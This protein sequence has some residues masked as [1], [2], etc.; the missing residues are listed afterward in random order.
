[1]VDQRV[2][3]IQ[4]WSGLGSSSVL[5]SI[6][7][8][9][10]SR[11]AIPKLCF[12]RIILIDS[13]EWRSRR[14]MQRAIAEELK[15]D[16]STM[17][18]ID[19]QDEEDDFY[20][21][22]DRSRGEIAAVSRK[23]N[24]I[25]KDSRFVMLFHK[26]CDEEIVLYG[27]GVPRF[28]KF[29]DNLLIWTSGRRR[30][31]F[32][33]NDITTR[34]N[35]QVYEG[36]VNLTNEQFYA[37]LCKEGAIIAPGI[38]P[39]VVS[40]CFLYKLLL[41]VSFLTTTKYDWAGHAFNCWICDGILQVDISREISNVLRRKISM[42]GDAYLLDY[43]LRKFKKYLKLPFLRVKDGDVYEEG[44]YRWISM[45]SKDT[46][47]HGMQI[48]PAQTSSFFLEFE[49]SEPLLAL[50]TGLFEHSSILGVL[51]LC[52]CAF[53]FA[54]PPFAKCHSLKFLGLDH[55]TDNNTCEVEDHTEWVC[56]YLL[57][58][59]DLHYTKW[60]EILSIKNIDLMTNIRE[61]NI[62]GFICWQ[63]TTHLQ[64][65]L[66]NLER[67][68]IIKPGSEP[69]ISLDT[70][71]SFLG[72]TKL[73]ILDLSGN[74]NM[75]V[76]PSSLSEVSSLDVLVL[77]GCTKLQDVV[78]DVLPHLLRSFRLD[79]YGPP[80]RRIPNVEQPMEHISS[81]TPFR[82]KKIS[83][84]TGSNK[85]GSNNISRI[86]LQGC[87]RLDSLFLRGLP[88][89]VELDLSGS[90]IK[91][92]DFETMVVEVPGLKRLFLLGC[93]HLRAIGW[94]KRWILYSTK[95][96]LEL[97]CIDTRA[98]TV[99]PRP[100]LSKNK[101][102]RLQVHAVV[103][104]ARLAWSL[105]PPMIMGARD[106]GLKE[107]YFNIH[108]TSSL[109]HN[110]SV[111]LREL[112]KKKTSMHGDQVSMQLSGIPPGSQY[113]DVFSMVSAVPLMQAFPEP[114]TSNLDYHIEIGEGGRSLE[115]AL[116]GHNNNDYNYN[117]RNLA[118]IMKWFAESLHVHDVSVSG[119]MPMGYWNMLKQCRMERCPKL[120]TVFP[121]GSQ[122]NSSGSS[123]FETL[124]T[125]WACDLLMARQIWSKGSHINVTS[126]KSFRNLQHLHLSSCPRLQFMLPVWVSSFPSLETLHIIHCG[127]L[128]HIFVLDGWYPEEIATNGVAFP[129]L[130]A[131]YLHDLPT[132]R[133]ISEMMMVAP[134]LETIKIRGCW[135]LSRLPAMNKSRGP[136]MKK[137]TVE[138]E[139][140][141]WDAL[142]WDGVEA[143]HHPSHF[144][145]PVHSRYYKKKLPR[146]SVL[147]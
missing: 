22:H 56:L 137:P 83:S 37:I 7:E 2:F 108:V 55:C 111:Q 139:K 132:L 87:T 85:N 119:S 102:L 143:G 9:L 59:L 31:I 6:A 117:D 121:W 54:S 88:N 67:L 101:P 109:V 110:G 44:P 122:G 94:G 49:R 90:A 141:V 127:D 15:L 126:T 66:P 19:E 26:G 72:R 65:R 100:P 43:M 45:T 12:D 133:Q 107:V 63:Y 125:F 80:S 131:I 115:S 17:A 28:G 71:N 27:F 18:I 14:S 140:D 84:S 69:E 91:V 51:I 114:P 116:D 42:E 64:G 58:V 39:T 104:D 50:P 70:S 46:K 40:D 74:S 61:L 89:L 8:L 76:L 130:T 93:E 75:E 60:N 145:A 82:K 129:K 24:H 62:E 134:I 79:A 92:L 124:E 147:R 25:L 97:L 95:P 1:M 47:L 29:E 4:V 135:S 20:G 53:N 38:D 10:P 21:V 57:R 106:D 138:I 16:C 48:V 77:D 13:S 136:G 112:C 5:R 118:F 30:L 103:E 105:C 36:I 99:R 68:R 52:C 123:G 142:E 98:G 113:M 34:A 23:I 120:G 96:D 11:R 78:P 41:H 144:E 128:K 81:S 73:E 35:L 33:E 146:T 86:S 3:Y 32:K